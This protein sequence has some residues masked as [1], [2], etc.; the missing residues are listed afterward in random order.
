[1]GIDDD[2][3]VK[4]ASGKALSETDQT[5]EEAGTCETAT[6]EEAKAADEAKKMTN[7]EEEEAKKREEM[8][9]Q[10]LQRRYR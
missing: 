4:L 9:T 2:A 5:M 7:G 8:E 1:M 10:K 3:S 6:G